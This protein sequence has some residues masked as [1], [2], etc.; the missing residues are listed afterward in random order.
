MLSRTTQ[1][2]FRWRCVQAARVPLRCYGAVVGRDT[3]M[4][5]VLSEETSTRASA[6]MTIDASAENVRPATRSAHP[7]T[8]EHH[9]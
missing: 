9:E 1:H 7:Q 3:A 2:A 4:R 5:V 8:K 6:G